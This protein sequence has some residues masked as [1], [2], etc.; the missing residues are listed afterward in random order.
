LRILLEQAEQ[1]AKSDLVRKRVRQVGDAFG[2]TERFVAMQETRDRVNRLAFD[3]RR[4]T[5]GGGRRTEDPASLMRASQGAAEELAAALAEFISTRSEFVRYTQAL[6]AEQPLLI[7]PFIMDDYL[8]NDPTASAVAKAMADSSRRSASGEEDFASLMR[9]SQGAAEGRE[10]AELAASI[11]AVQRDGRELAINGGLAGPLKPERQSAGLTYSVALPEPWQ[12]RVEPVQWHRVAWSGDAA[13]VLK[14]SGTK[15]TAVFQWCALDGATF[16]LAQAE[17]R[18]RVS[19]SGVAMLTIGWLD[20]QQ[21][22]LGTTVIRL[23]EGEWH[24]WQTLRHAAK[25]PAGA[26]WVGVGIRIQHQ[27]KDDWV[28]VKEFSLK[29]K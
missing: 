17:M 24:G 3:G 27:L 23:P 15:D 29:A 14:I 20:S 12:S 9:A 16:A 28:E 22:H 19:S 1:R 2:V 6:Q 11:A 5:E 7:A 21:R 10:L 13:R 26:V 4:K 18:G 8:R 25:A